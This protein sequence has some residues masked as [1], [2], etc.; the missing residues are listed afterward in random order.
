LAVFVAHQQYK[1][2]YMILISFYRLQQ[3]YKNVERY[4]ENMQCTANREQ[5]QTTNDHPGDIMFAKLP[6]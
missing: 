6:S 5:Q 3:T 1:N 4:G 2:K